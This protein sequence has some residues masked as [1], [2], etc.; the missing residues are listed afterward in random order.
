M[1]H[2]C[3]GKLQ[4]KKVVMGALFLDK[5]QPT[6]TGMKLCRGI[7]TATKKEV[8]L[9]SDKTYCKKNERE[10]NFDQ[11]KPSFTIFKAVQRPLLTWVESS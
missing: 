3:I 5:S 1:S 7:L 6:K 4:H 9:M 10:L 2:G 8:L 11:S